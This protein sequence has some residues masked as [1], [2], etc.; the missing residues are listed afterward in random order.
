MRSMI[1]WRGASLFDGAEVQVVLTGLGAR[2][3]NAK[4]GGMIQASIMRPGSQP[5]REFGTPR[6]VAVCGACPLRGQRDGDVWR[7]R[8][9]CYAWWAAWLLGQ[10]AA[11]YRTA[12]L[13]EGRIACAGR[14]LRLGSYG[15]PA[16][17]PFDVWNE[18]IADVRGWTAYTHAW[19]TCDPRFRYLAM[20]SV[21]TRDDYLEAQRRGWR[22][23]RTKIEGTMRYPNEIDCPARAERCDACRSKSYQ[24]LACADRSLTCEKCRLCN[25]KSTLARN[26]VIDAHGSG[27]A[28]LINV[29]QGRLAL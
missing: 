3:R 20:A 27:A 21:E 14:L 13:V 11:R 18:L 10:H 1:V 8:R 22:T 28:H 15:D 16:A 6:E 4:T 29:V 9:V 25:G 12:S 2:S 17:V 23:F 5:S 24:C 26:I 7:E 19:Q